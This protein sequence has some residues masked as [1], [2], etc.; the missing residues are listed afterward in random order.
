MAIHDV[1]SLDDGLDAATMYADI[2]KA[3]ELENDNH[4]DWRTLFTMGPLQY[5][6]RI[7]LA[8]GTQAM[9]QLTGISECSYQESNSLACPNAD[10]MKDVIA[11]YSAVVFE[12]SVHM[13][14]NL[15]LLMAGFVSL[16]WLFGSLIGVSLIDKV[17]RRRVSIIASIGFFTVGGQLTACSS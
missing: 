3:V 11:Y 10:D 17:G 7:L 15:S 12:Q 5:F 13:S 2:H 16:A 14:R 1:A 6:R 8:F 9:Q 4:S